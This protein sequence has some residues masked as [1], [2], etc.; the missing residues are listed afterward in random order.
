MSILDCPKLKS[1]RCREP[2]S[3]TG[4]ST[5]EAILT[6]LGAHTGAGPLY[7]DTLLTLHSI[8]FQY[9]GLLFFFYQTTGNV[10]PQH[11]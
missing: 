11:Y 8:N 2:S 3:T 4:R 5:P 9:S 10:S 6:S 7:A 1:L